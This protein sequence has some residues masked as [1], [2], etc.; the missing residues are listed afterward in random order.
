LIADNFE[1]FC[2]SL[3]EAFENVDEHLGKKIE[4]LKVVLF[5]CHF[6]IKA[7]EFAQMTISV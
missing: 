7:C 5:E 2:E 6:D 4:D 3:V 1:F